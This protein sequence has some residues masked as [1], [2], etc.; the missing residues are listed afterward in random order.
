MHTREMKTRSLIKLRGDRMVSF[1]SSKVDASRIGIFVKELSFAKAKGTVGTEPW[2][3]KLAIFIDRLNFE[4]R[5]RKRKEKEK[6]KKRK[7]K[8]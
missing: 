5:E 4:L 1:L 6:K 2:R 7:K 8:G 3:S